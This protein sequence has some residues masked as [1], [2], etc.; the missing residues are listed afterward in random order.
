MGIPMSIEMEMKVNNSAALESLGREIVRCRRCPRLVAWRE[1]VAREKRAAFADQEYWGRPLR[2]F[3]D[4]QAWLLVVGLAPA[5]HGANRTGRMFTGDRSGD[6]LYAALHR[7]GL[8]NRAESTWRDD[9]LELSG[10]YITAAV[11]CAPPGNKP[12]PEERDNCRGYLARELELL[13]GVKVILALGGYAFG[14]VLRILRDRGAAVP[15]PAP[16]FAHGAVVKLRDSGLAVIASYHPSQ[17]NT[18]TGK[19]TPRMLDGV[20][21]KAKTLAAP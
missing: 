2:G 17:Q 5:A 6:F 1:K 19:L 16:K 11:R 21:A 7:A 3:G 18:F 14:H 13:N 4:P 10:T 8:A 9:G 20:L 15:V 12:A